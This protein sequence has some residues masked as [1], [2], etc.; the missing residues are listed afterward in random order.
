MTASGEPRLDQAL[1]HAQFLRAVARGVLGGDAEV[2]DVLQETFLVAWKEGP[3]QPGALR[4]WLAGIARRLALMR[5]R[6]H[7]RQA[8]RERGAAKPEGIPSVEEVALRE[9]ARRKLVDAL[10]ALEDPYRTT[11]LWRYYAGRSV[12]DIAALQN[13]PVNTVR[14]RVQRGLA[15]LR[16][17][18]D[19]AYRQDRRAWQAALVPL[20]SGGWI[21]SGS[22]AAAVV[23]GVVMQKG[24]VAAVAALV[25]V[26]AGALAW[27]VNRA[28][29][30]PAET[31]TGSE[32]AA[33]QPVES[34]ENIAPELATRGGPKANE[35]E[36][37]A[38]EA[39][40]AGI[41]VDGSGRAVAGAQ[42]TV[43]AACMDADGRSRCLD[44]R[45]DEPLAKAATAADGAFRL[46]V[47]AER[48]PWLPK[49]PSLVVHVAAPGFAHAEAVVVREK[50]ARIVLGRGGA[51]SFTMLDEEGGPTAGARVALYRGQAEIPAVGWS[52]IP[53]V[54]AQ[55]VDSSGLLELRLAAGTYRARVTAEGRRPV[56]SRPLEVVEGKT[57]SIE[58]RL[59][60]GIVVDVFATGP[61]GGPVVG[62]RVRLVGPL[63]SGGTAVT[64]TDGKATIAGIALPLGDNHRDRYTQSAQTVDFAVEADGLAGLYGS[65][66]LPPN[67][68]RIRIDA[69]LGPGGQLRVRIVGSD[70]QPLNP[71]SA[72]WTRGIY[73]EPLF[74][75]HEVSADSAGWIAMP[76]LK[77]GSYQLALRV[78]GDA[79]TDRTETIVLTE[80]D[81]TRTF[82]LE[83]ARG[84][85]TGTVLMPDGSPATEGGI[86][87]EPDTPPGMA[88]A[89]GNAMGIGLDGTF[90]L[91]GLKVGSGVLVVSMPGRAGQRHSATVT[92]SESTPITVRLRPTLPIR[93]RVAA[94][95]GTNV[96]ACK[97]HLAHALMK[98]SP[99][100]QRWEHQEI[101]TEV[102][103][104]ADGAFEVEAE[105][106][107]AFRIWAYN[108]AW[109]GMQGN[110]R[111]A[112]AGDTRVL[113]RVKPRSE[114]S[115]LPLHLRVTSGG[116]PY[117][118]GLDVSYMHATGRRFATNAGTDGAGLYHFGVWGEP[119]TYTVTLNARGHRPT[120]LR[121]LAL[122]ETP[123]GLTRDVALDRGSVFRLRLR[124]A[125]GNPITGTHVSVNGTPLL[126]DVHGEVEVGGFE[127]DGR[128]LDL[129]VALA[130]DPEFT[131]VRIRIVERAGTYDGVLRRCGIV[132]V[133]LGSRW[134]DV[135]DQ[136][137]ARALN[138]AGEVVDERRYPAAELARYSAYPIQLELRVPADGTYKID[139]QLDARAGEAPVE[140]R[141]GQRT[142][143]TVELAKAP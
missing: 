87:F 69:P 48:I 16:T 93:G 96:A 64:G 91:G 95:D 38:V 62:A 108:N 109:Q 88:P 40:Y 50:L 114:P 61:G 5:R 18:L 71:A 26:G 68:D 63:E 9:E 58:M 135:R 27:Q 143:L 83:S 17:E 116:R 45:D 10:L 74:P 51:L 8:A 42:V 15:H 19:V 56:H 49:P 142:D 77:P 36:A 112:E 84:L 82:V 101:G 102:S 86:R 59:D 94:R 100:E 138:A 132:T 72:H 125:A 7:G 80:A 113:L 141:V 57:T 133:R 103:T 123:E 120:D 55:A 76:K 139:V 3:R 126:P 85:L 104:D 119:G 53:L 34:A 89:F 30:R 54:L 31:R 122:V 67:R 140:A 20:A 81:E 110:P 25:L 13:V 111:T 121:D 29:P 105:P 78:H 28:E 118:G 14:T 99:G 137:V 92:A 46:V 73:Q 124:D 90:G 66:R 79:Q 47:P 24:V 2:E 52:G 75:S 22:A 131:Q 4:A 127:K 44:V 35:K 37:A 130:A 60:T 33:P 6:T 39:T 21:V 117:T 136:L 97:V 12:A 106:G 23:G 128:P 1:A 134:T 129:P 41:V 32:G 11:L 107:I 115:G 65:R 98:M 70:G 43:Q